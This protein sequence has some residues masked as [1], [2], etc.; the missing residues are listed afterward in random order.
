MAK[1]LDGFEFDGKRGPPP[2]YPWHQW[3]DGQAWHLE[4]GVDYYVATRS[5]KATI[6]NAAINRGKLVRMKR[7]KD[8]TSEG[9][10]LQVYGSGER[11]G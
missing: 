1:V 2:S 7:F 8:G 9:I 10:V 3:F 6:F 11:R 4:Q 5:M